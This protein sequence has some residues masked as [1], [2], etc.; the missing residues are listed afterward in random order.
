M[1]AW[2]ERKFAPAYE[3]LRPWRVGIVPLSFT[4]GTVP[5]A[6][7]MSAVHPIQEF[8]ALA[9]M[10]CE[11]YIGPH[12][13]CRGSS[14]SR[15]QQEDPMRAWT[16]SLLAVLPWLPPA[17]LPRAPAAPCSVA[18]D[19]QVQAHLDWGLLEW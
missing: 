4:R 11:P 7:S 16:S 9:F 2:A 5:K 3:K 13:R 10:A 1:P 18:V 6:A 17:D 19:V 14:A 8:I 15:G 12:T